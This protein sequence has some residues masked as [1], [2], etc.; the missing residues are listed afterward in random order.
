MKR[1]TC[2]TLL[3]LFVAM[4]CGCAGLGEARRTGL[5]IEPQDA[6]R[7]GYNVN[8]S[9]DLQVPRSSR[10]SA[11][12]VLDDL[13]LV[14]QTPS[15]LVTAIEA[16]NG[17]TRWWRIVG[18]KNDRVFTPVREGD[19]IYVNTETHIYTLSAKDG[20]L[21]SGAPLEQV[22]T[23]G[24]A[25]IN[26]FAI[27]GGIEGMVFG[28]DVNL[29]LSRWEYQLTARVLTPPVP[30]GLDVLVADGNGVY[31]VLTALDGT[32]VWRG[33]TFGAVSVPPAADRTSVY[34]ASEDQT[35]YALDRSTGKDKWVYRADQA[36]KVPPTA[37]GMMVYLP[38]PGDGLVALDAVDGTER[39]RLAEAA[40]PV[41]VVDEQLLAATSG[42]LRRVDLETGEVLVQ[43]TTHKL[44]TVLNG[45][46]SSIILVSPRGRLTRLNPMGR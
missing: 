4:A 13:I 23:T 22:V 24:P 14:V 29:G 44:S 7:V 32:L 15:N 5:L 43:A 21:I 34:I 40:W 37:M 8:W 41:T 2:R 16:R 36:L 1:T 30:A 25:L 45:P 46:D 39:W 27:F 35:L 38:L 10:M 26:N 11:V 3:C 9:T 20:K 18:S 33:R 19:R 31:A 17:D 42:A 6:G 28:H 12:T